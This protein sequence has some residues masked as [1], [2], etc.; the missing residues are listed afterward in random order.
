MTGKRLAEMNYPYLKLISSTMTR[1]K[2]T[3]DII[4]KHLPELERE[5]DAL[6]REGAPIPPEPPSGNWR[7]EAAVCVCTIHLS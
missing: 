7:P 6:L 5:E 3:A 1:A 2:E 4:H